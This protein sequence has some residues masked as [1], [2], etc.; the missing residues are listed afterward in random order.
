LEEEGSPMRKPGIG[1]ALQ[2]KK[3]FP[4]IDFTKSI[5]IGDSKKDLEFGKRTKMI[6]ILIYDESANKVEGYSIASLFDFNE[7][8]TSILQPV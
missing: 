3:D 2:A 7:L 5:L 8:L 1:M 6:S 4:E